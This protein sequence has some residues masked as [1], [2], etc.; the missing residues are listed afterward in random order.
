MLKPLRLWLWKRVWKVIIGFYSHSTKWTGLD[1]TGLDW[2]GLDWTGLDWTGLDWTGL[3]WNGM[4]WNGMES[5]WSPS[6]LR[7]VFGDHKVSM[8][9]MTCLGFQETC[10]LRGDYYITT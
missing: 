8:S 2:T 1:W 9:L 6:S 5:R 7:I 3:D 10:L 4:E